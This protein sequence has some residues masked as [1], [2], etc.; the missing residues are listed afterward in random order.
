MFAERSGDEEDK[1]N[2]MAGL[3]TKKGIGSNKN[4]D[5]EKKPQRSHGSK[6]DNTKLVESS[7]SERMMTTKDEHYSY[8]I[9]VR[10]LQKPTVKKSF[11]RFF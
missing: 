3:E 7:D 2:P 1:I 4:K 11:I 9:T 8:R 5:F 10:S 6:K